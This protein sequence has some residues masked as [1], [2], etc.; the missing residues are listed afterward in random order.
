[1]LECLPVH[2]KYSS[3]TASLNFYLIQ[4]MTDAVE[5]QMSKNKALYS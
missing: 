4:I 2:I 3:S 5:I 1:M